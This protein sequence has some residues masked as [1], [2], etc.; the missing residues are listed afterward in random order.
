MTELE[1]ELLCLFTKR[2]SPGIQRLFT[3]LDILLKVR[4]A[5]TLN[6]E[7]SQL[8]GKT[9]EIQ[10]LF[11]TYPGAAGRGGGGCLCPQGGCEP[12]SG[13]RAALPRLLRRR[14]LGGACARAL[15]WRERLTRPLP[16]HS[17]AAALRPAGPR[18]PSSPA[19][20]NACPLLLPQAQTNVQIHAYTEHVQP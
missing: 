4:W 6:T 19:E 8:F 2:A 15:A 12:R 7:N 20:V 9:D 5:S 13:S 17:A 18:A 3:L 16:E 11:P 10:K 14:S 1:L